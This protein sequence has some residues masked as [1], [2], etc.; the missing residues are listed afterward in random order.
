[1]ILFAAVAFG[2]KKDTVVAPAVSVPKGYLVVNCD[3]CQVQYGMPDQ[4]KQISVSGTSVKATYSYTGTYT[5]VA[6]ITPINV[7]QTVTISVFDKSGTL[8]YTGSKL[9]QPTSYWETDTVVGSTE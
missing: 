6:Y 2:C 9:Q 5:V 1:M 8:V 7:A 3:N 4:Y